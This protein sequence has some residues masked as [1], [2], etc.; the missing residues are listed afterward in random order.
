MGVQKKECIDMDEKKGNKN[1]DLVISGLK[2][3]I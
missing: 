1:L 3:S 2:S